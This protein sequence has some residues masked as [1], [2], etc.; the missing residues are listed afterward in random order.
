VIFSG[1]WETGNASQWTAVQCANYTPAPPGSGN[2][3][4]LN[5][6]EDVVAQGRYAAR[7][8][9]PAEEKEHTSCE[10]LHQRPEGIGTDDWYALEV[11]FPSNWQE[12]QKSWWGL[13]L[14]QFS[15]SNMG[16]G[17]PLGMCA[18]SDHVNLGLESGR[19]EG[20]APAQCQFTTGNDAP[21]NSDGSPSEG[22]LKTTLRLIPK[23]TALAETWQQF[24]VHVHWAKD[25]SGV[26]EGWWRP[27]GGG[28]WVKTVNLSGYPTVQWTETI[29][30]R[31]T[32]NDKI[33]AYRGKS[34]FPISIWN[35]GFC[36]AT[37]FAG[38]ASCL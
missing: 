8:D 11:R 23:G 6:V 10:V 13:C 38:A 2:I 32:T 19:C 27:R 3:G 17:A 15:F 14:A 25:S 37:S 30:E 5:L 16:A 12:P 34:T 29:S 1:N 26:V 28:E 33:G 18:H 7:F 35:D 4:N 21:N 36:V 31:A 24:I 20:A 22:T 9:L